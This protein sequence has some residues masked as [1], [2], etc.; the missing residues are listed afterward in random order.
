MTDADVEIPELNRAQ[1]HELIRLKNNLAVDSRET[2]A[3]HATD[4]SRSIPPNLNH[5]LSLD[6]DTLPVGG[7]RRHES[8]TLTPPHTGRSKTRNLTGSRGS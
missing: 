5:K 6:G 3:E 1:K 2:K 4:R 7:P 8:P